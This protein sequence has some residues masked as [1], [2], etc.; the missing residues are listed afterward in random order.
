L[1][2]GIASGV[3][4]DLLLDRLPWAHCSWRCHFCNRSSS[5]L[6]SSSPSLSVRLWCQFSIPILKAAT[7]TVSIIDLCIA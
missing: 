5:S 4:A 3:P 1:L 2:L 7:Q 6:A